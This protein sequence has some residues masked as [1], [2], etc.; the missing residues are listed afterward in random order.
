MNTSKQTAPIIVET[1]SPWTAPVLDMMDMG[2]AEGSPGAP[3]GDT[4]TTGS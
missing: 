3:L 1:K 2:Q 4:T